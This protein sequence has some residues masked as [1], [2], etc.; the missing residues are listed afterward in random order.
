MQPVLHRDDKCLSFKICFL[1][2][3]FKTFR[4]RNF[5]GASAVYLLFYVKLNVNVIYLERLTVP[6]LTIWHKNKLIYILVRAVYLMH[7]GSPLPISQHNVG[8]QYHYATCVG[9]CIN[10]WTIT[11]IFF[12]VRRTS[13]K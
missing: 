5:C 4:I 1:A 13:C 2:V 8:S 9:L 3:N 7:L 6:K 11:E 10:V 12:K